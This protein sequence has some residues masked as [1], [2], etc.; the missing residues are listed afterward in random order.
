MKIHN[1]LYFIGLA[2]VFT[3]IFVVLVI[4]LTF[5]TFFIV[6]TLVTIGIAVG[7]LGASKS[8]DYEKSMTEN[9]NE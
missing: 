3:P 4:G 2:T 9:K 1:I 5:S 7:L 6:I 8:Y